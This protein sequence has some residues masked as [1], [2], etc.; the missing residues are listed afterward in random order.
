MALLSSKVQLL[1]LMSGK[2]IDRKIAVIFATDV[3]GYSKH[4]EADKSYTIINLRECEAIL[5]DLFKKHCGHL[6]V[7]AVTLFWPNFSVRFLPLI[8]LY[9]FRGKLRSGILLRI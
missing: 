1:S 8:V 9:N 2:M 6:L 5:L 4:L 3:V 7:Q